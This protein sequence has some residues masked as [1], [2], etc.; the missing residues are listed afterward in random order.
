MSCADFPGYV[1]DLVKLGVISYETYVADGH[2]VYSGSDNDQISSQPIYNQLFI[3]EKCDAEQFISDLK[4]HQQGQ[5][6]YAE[7]CDDCAKSGILKWAVST[8]KMSCTYFD[9]AGN[10]VLT[11]LIPL[12]IK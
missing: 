12:H 2:S 4:A 10:E 11:E 6:N 8:E 5:T 1:P 7:F 3:A 9:L